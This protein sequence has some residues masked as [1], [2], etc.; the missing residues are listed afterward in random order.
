MAHNEAK[1]QSTE[2]DPEMTQTIELAH[3]NSYY[4]CSLYV[5]EARKKTG[6]IKYRCIRDF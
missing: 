2:P 3:K 1:Y 6:P 4:N 5:Q